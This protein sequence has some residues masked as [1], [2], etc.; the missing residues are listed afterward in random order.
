MITCLKSD[1]VFRRSLG[2][3]YF[4]NTPS[5]ATLKRFIKTLAESDILEKT[6]RRMVSKARQLV[7]PMNMPMC[8][9]VMI[10]EPSVFF[11]H[12]H[13]ANVIVR[14]VPHGAPLLNIR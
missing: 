7:C 2:Y 13:E 3:D 4:E 6:F 11:V 5:E 10:T 14:W 12:M 8:M 9:A 1:P